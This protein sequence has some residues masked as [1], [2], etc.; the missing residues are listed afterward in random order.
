MRQ[1]FKATSRRRSRPTW[2]LATSS[3]RLDLLRAT[4]AIFEQRHLQLVIRHDAGYGWPRRL[5]EAFP[6]LKQEEWRT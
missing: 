5:G 1:V 3:V 2:I 4:L 6:L